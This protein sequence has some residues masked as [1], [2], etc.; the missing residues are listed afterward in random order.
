MGKERYA[1]MDSGSWVMYTIHRAAMAT[2]QR[3]DGQKGD[4]LEEMCSDGWLYRGYIHRKEVSLIQM[5]NY[6][7]CG[8][9]E[10]SINTNIYIY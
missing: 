10:Q 8:P 6:G 3:T 9:N 7:M 5:Y 4:W 2:K 1:G